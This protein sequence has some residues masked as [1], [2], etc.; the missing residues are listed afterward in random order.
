MWGDRERGT[1]GLRGAP[2]WERERGDRDE[3]GWWGCPKMVEWEVREHLRAK[4]KCKA[5]DEGIIQM[6]SGQ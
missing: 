5:G 2:G 3:F 1:V 4:Q 6:P